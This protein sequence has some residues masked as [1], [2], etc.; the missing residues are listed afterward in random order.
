MV[1]T[2]NAVDDPV[3]LDQPQPAPASKRGSTTVRSPPAKLT[4]RPSIPPTWNEGTHIS[5][6]VDGRPGS[7]GGR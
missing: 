6:T 4:S 7:T 5:D 2:T 1:G 3:A